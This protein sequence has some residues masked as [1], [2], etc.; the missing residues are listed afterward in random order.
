MLR[1]HT[2]IVFGYRGLDI[3]LDNALGDTWWSWRHST[4]YG[5]VMVSFAD[6]LDEAANDARASVD[7]YLSHAEE[8][9]DRFGVLSLYGAI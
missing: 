8:P 3:S 4:I 5:G 9:F 1:K 2:R 7:Q 6:S